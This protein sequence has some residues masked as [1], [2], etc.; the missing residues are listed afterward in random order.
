MNAPRQEKNRISRTVIDRIAVQL[1][2][3]ESTANTMGGSIMETILLL[4]EE[5]ERKAE[6]RR[7]DEEKHRSEERAEAKAEAE[8]R[9]HR[10]KMEMEERARRDREEARART[11]ELLLLI[12]ALTKKD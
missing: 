5:N 2:G 4:R 10:D 1:N 12:G 11:Q 9:R 8:E 3:L 7:V 6:A